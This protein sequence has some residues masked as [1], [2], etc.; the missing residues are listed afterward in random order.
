MSLGTCYL[1]SPTWFSTAWPPIKFRCSLFECIAET[2]S[3]HNDKSYWCVHNQ[4]CG[5]WW[6]CLHLRM[7]WHQKHQYWYL[8]FYEISNLFQILC[9]GN[10][11]KSYSYSLFISWL[12]ITWRLRTS[13]ALVLITMHG[14]WWP[15]SP[16]RIALS[17]AQVPGNKSFMVCAAWFKSEITMSCWV[18]SGLPCS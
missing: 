4:F 11:V 17:A 7:P 3:T 18:S 12:L 6:H 10:H 5:C 9:P 8:V 1:V 13:L 14:C 16:G 2:H 15:D